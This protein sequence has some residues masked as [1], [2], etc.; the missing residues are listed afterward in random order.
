MTIRRVVFAPDSFKG[1][2]T[3]VNAAKALAEGWASVRPSDE[4]VLRP[5]ADGGEGTVAAFEAASPGARRMP[6]DVEGPAGRRIRTSWLLLPPTAEDPDGIAVVDVASTSGI[7]LLDE[8]L[9]WD[10]GTDGCGQ[11]IIAALEHG[12]S[13]LVI[14]IGSSA[15]TDGGMGLLRTL[16][17]RFLDSSGA[18]V[19]TRGAAGLCE[20]ASVD[21]AELRAAPRVIA[22]SDVT[23]PLTGPLGAAAV[24]GPQKGLVAPEDI[25]R[26]DI[27][28]ARLA[29]F[30]GVSATTPGSG[31]AG[32]LGAALISWGAI[33]VP[34]ASEIASLIGLSDSLDDADFVVTGEGSYDGQSCDGK[35]AAFVAEN[36]AELGVRAALAAGQI[37][38]DVDTGMFAASVSLA[39]LAGSPKRAQQN[40]ARWLR[41]AGARLAQANEARMV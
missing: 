11:A 18:A 20:V 5:M 37:A 27:A 25:A 24:Y 34:G 4:V 14:G 30:L 36:A 33:L 15:S 22:L 38:P 28:L 3:A 19:V 1:T 8:P 41:C 32:G 7:E 31:A 6:L 23:N 26:V 40:T 29:D 17:A 10:A 9:P 35:A 21:L 13:T 39:G 2:I 12:V 16:G